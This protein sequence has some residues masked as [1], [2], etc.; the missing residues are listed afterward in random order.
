[1]GAVLRDAGIQQALENSGDW[2]SLALIE[3]EQI[4]KSRRHELNEFTFEMLK[5]PIV[6]TCGLPHS[7]AVWGGISKTA[8][9]RGWIADTGKTCTAKSASRHASLARIYRWV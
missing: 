9:R 5:A 4:W 7:S 8:V 2:K 3:M 1:M 6:I